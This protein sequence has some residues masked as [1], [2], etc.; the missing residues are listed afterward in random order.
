MRSCGCRTELLLLCFDSQFS[1]PYDACL[2]GI[3]LGDF[4]AERR[5]SLNLEVFVL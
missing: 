3:I 2:L 5:L 1:F 4:H